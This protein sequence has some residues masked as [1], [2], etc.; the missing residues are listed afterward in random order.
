MILVAFLL[1][2]SRFDST[3][4]WLMVS[5]F[6]VRFRVVSILAVLDILLAS[7][8]AGA[9]IALSVPDTLSVADCVRLA[10]ERSPEARAAAAEQT[11]AHFDSSAASHPRRPA[12]SFFGGA[13][14][15]PRHFYDPAITN[16]GDYSAKLG[17]SWNWLDGGASRREA[18]RGALGARQAALA[19]QVSERDAALAAGALALMTARLDEARQ[20]QSE[21]VGWLERLASEMNAGVRA[22]AHG[23][24]DALRVVLERDAAATALRATLHEALDTARDLAHWLGVA[25]AAAPVVRAPAT[26]GGPLA[27]DEADSL[28]VLAAFQ[29]GVEVELARADEAAARLALDDAVRKDAWKVGLSA[30]AGLAGTDLTGAVPNDLKAGHPDATFADRLHRD[31]GASASVAFQLPLADIT[32]PASVV[33]RRAA[34]DAATIRREA[35][36]AK[37]ERDA[38]ELLA[39]WRA[40]AAEHAAVHASLARAEEHLLRVRSL[41]AAGA[42]TLLELLDARRL[43]DDAR[44]READARYDVQRARL[45]S[46][47]R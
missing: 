28:R 41:Y 7:L 11:A 47:V 31:L 38:A 17:V 14:I 27:L 29:R 43:Y 46:E 32:Q 8:P 1:F 34:L 19:R 9:G 33:A 20:A 23:Q 35:A 44:G 10:R 6:R 37:Q 5:A 18:A 24:S 40:G 25:P 2:T 26:P 45:E 39:R 42:T 3:M 12:Y 22:G 21:A 15:A 16:L 30:D 36:A 13:T 4:K